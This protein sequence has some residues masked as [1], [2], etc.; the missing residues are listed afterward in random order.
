MQG[1]GAV[2]LPYQII[3]ALVKGLPAELHKVKVS[4]LATFSVQ[5]FKETLPILTGVAYAV[6]FNDRLPRMDM[7]A[8]R[9]AP[10]VPTP[11]TSEPIQVRCLA[12]WVERCVV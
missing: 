4:L 3:K 8:D 1:N 6:G 10:G 2:L 12:D 11:S 7:A 9:L 5:D